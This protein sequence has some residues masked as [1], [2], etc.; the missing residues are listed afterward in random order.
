MVEAESILINSG[1]T[2]ESG[3]YNVAGISFDLG[4]PVI[5]AKV[6]DHSINGLNSLDL[7][8]ILRHALN[9]ELLEHADQKAAAGRQQ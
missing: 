4:R 3:I 5:K 7:I 1:M 2:N 9:I 8:Y 6:D